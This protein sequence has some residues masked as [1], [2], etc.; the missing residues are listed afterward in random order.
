MKA[1][2]LIDGFNLYFSMNDNRYSKYKWLD[3]SKLFRNYVNSRDKIEIHYFTTVNYKDIHSYKTDRIRIDGKY[4]RHMILIEA[5]ET[6]GVI[7]HYGNFMDTDYI[8]ENCKHHNIR[9]KEKQTDVN[10][11]AFLSYLAF[12]RNLEKFIILSADTDMI[13]AISLVKEISPEK[14]ISLLLPPGYAF[15]EISK[16]CD[17][18]YQMEEEILKSS[19]FPRTVLN[20]KGEEI[21]CPEE[22][23]NF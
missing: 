22:W 5:E 17:K 4:K 23:A 2:A 7:V 14:H 18:T 10:I 20:E 1:A 19:M 8:C 6:K 9:R 15:S 13:P 11:G 16:F 12:S 3:F 21:T